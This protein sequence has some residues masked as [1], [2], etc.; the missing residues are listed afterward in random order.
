MKEQVWRQGKQHGTV[1][2][3][4]PPGSKGIYQ[5]E[6]VEVEYYG[7]FLIAESIQRK[8]LVALIAAAPELLA[9]LQEAV[10][11]MTLLGK[12]IPKAW[13][14]ALVKATGFSHKPEKSERLLPEQSKS[15][16]P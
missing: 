15:K 12:E 4:Y 3:D 13:H 1:V 7:G 9:C 5:K 10:M 14:Q 8:E 6:E 2:A 16:T 11:T